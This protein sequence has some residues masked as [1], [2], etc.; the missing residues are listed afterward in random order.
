MNL[1]VGIDRHLALYAEL[2]RKKRT[3]GF[4]FQA[5]LLADVSFKSWDAKEIGVLM[6][7]TYK[8]ARVDPILK[9]QIWIST[10]STC[11]V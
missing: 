10:V 4:F 11:D 7:S 3:E 9:Y 8:R 5:A 6:H 2:H 1:R